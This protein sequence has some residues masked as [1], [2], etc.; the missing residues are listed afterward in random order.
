[1][2][3]PASFRSIRQRLSAIY[4]EERPLLC[5]GLLGI[6]LGIIAFGVMAA[7]GRF[8]PPEG[9]I[10]KAATFDIAIG[11]YILTI[12]L[13]L[14]LSG[15]SSGGRRRWRLCSIALAIYA[16]AI[17]NIQIYRGLDPRFT[18]VGSPADQIAGVLFGLSALG[19][20]IM[21]LVLTLRFFSRRNAVKN[22][23]VLL[24]IRYAC[25]ATISAFAAGFWL[26]TNQGSH[27]GATGSIL[28]LH[29]AGFHGLQAI[30]LV[31]LLLS[32]SEMRAGTARRWVHTA[33]VAWLI[34]MVAI[35]RQTAAGRS[36]LEASPATVLAA[37]MLFVWFVCAAG[38]LVS[39]LRAFSAAQSF[40]ADSS[41]AA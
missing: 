31:A 41:L 27:V 25:V 26:G 28:P 37:L 33:G 39:C 21:F 22:E 18:R 2:K 34:M 7:R 38:A 10:Y 16:Y 32:W 5:L 6:V 36:V 4:G 9:Y 3:Q 24:G 17:E 23:L 35:A 12:I 15:L 1:M 40:D 8:V 19:L 13:Y 30:P 14:P 20:I 11:I 29:A